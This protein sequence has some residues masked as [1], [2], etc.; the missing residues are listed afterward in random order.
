MTSERSDSV[1]K[2][3]ALHDNSKS[4]GTGVSSTAVVKYS[5][6]EILPYNKLQQD[7]DLNV[8]PSNWL[9]DGRFSDV[10]HLRRDPV[11]FSRFAIF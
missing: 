3:A 2:E 10:D 9:R 11:E 8:A 5:A 4:S 1:C 7:T 6:Q